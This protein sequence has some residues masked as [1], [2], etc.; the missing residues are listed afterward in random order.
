[1]LT[2]TRT[3]TSAPSPLGV[4]AP[5]IVAMTKRQMETLLTRQHVGRVAFTPA[6]REIEIHPVHYVFADGAIY[7][8]TRFGA[9][10]VAWMH[11]PYVAFEVDE[12]LGVFE[13]QSVVVRGTVYILTDRGSKSERDDF[14][15]ARVAIRTLMPAAFTARDPTPYRDVVFRIE[16]HEMSGRAA[17]AH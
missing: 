16:P 6:E 17:S 10:Y 7:G 14:R 13:W 8:R 15:R 1:M 11:R 5:R 4:R 9:K 3:S 2:E 12:V